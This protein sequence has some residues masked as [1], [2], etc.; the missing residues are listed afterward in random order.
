MYFN[1][2]NGQESFEAFKRKH[3]RQNR[4]IIRLN[5][6]Q[7]V[8]VR[9][10]EIET[11]R[12]LQENFELRASLISLQEQHEK[13]K[14]KAQFE[15]LKI[16]KKTLENKL[17]E[18][19]DIVQNILPEPSSIENLRTEKKSEKM[20][21]SVSSLNSIQIETCLNEK[22]KKKIGVK[23]MEKNIKK[24]YNQSLHN[25]QTDINFDI[26]S[27]CSNMINSSNNDPANESLDSDD[28]SFIYIEKNAFNCIDKNAE[29]KQI[30]KEKVHDRKKIHR[31]AEENDA[32]G[33][34]IYTKP[35]TIVENNKQIEQFLETS[36]CKKAKNINIGKE[37]I[38]EHEI[39][40]KEINIDNNLI[41]NIKT[42]ETVP[43]KILESK[44]SIANKKIQSE[45][46]LKTL[47]KI[48]T[49]DS[50][51]H[52]PEI[53]NSLSPEKRTGRT[54]KA[55]NYALPSLK[56]K[57]R[58]DYMPVEEENMNKC[59]SRK[60]VSEDQSRNTSTES[61]IK[62]LSK[63]EKNTD[64]SFSSQTK[65]EKMPS[66]VISKPSLSKHN[67]PTSSTDSQKK[68][69]SKNQYTFKSPIK[70][71]SKKVVHDLSSPIGTDD[72][73]F[74]M[75]KKTTDNIK[76]QLYEDKRQ[77]IEELS[78]L[79]NSISL[80]SEYKDIQNQSEILERRKSMLA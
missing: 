32:F 5:M 42:K 72:N 21:G 35:K 17:S 51:L 45:N 50:N 47:E 33:S 37:N 20:N 77:K 59:Y 58:R 6:L 63:K 28:S 12:L 10:L 57:M 2:E 65:C 62:S 48:K 31:S 38:I 23:R 15:K 46:E 7:S 27:T 66:V 73:I 54:K 44:P 8:K 34:F 18:I 1:V 60:K 79:R 16:L 41:E 13:E 75:N 70:L 68:F 30:E 53:S 61:N 55:I 69:K 52:S 71:D 19:T 11:G 25:R 24:N 78:K 49:K 56:T 76:S 9:Q 64:I 43:R 29:L 40:S 39:S 80:I 67:S 26:N 4:E 36:N 74:C 22:S 3:L 14:K